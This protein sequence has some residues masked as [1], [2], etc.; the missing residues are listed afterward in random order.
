MHPR[1][2]PRRRRHHQLLRRSHPG[3][4]LAVPRAAPLSPHGAPAVQQQTHPGA[5]R[6]RRCGRFRRRWHPLRPVL[7][8]LHAAPQEGPHRHRGPQGSPPPPRESHGVHLPRRALR[9]QGKVL[10][11]RR[12][13]HGR[14]RPHAGAAHGGGR[15]A[16]VLPHAGVRP[17]LPLPQGGVHPVPALCHAGPHRRREPPA[18]DRGHGRPRG[19][20]RR[21]DGRDGDVPDRREA[22]RGPHERA[23]G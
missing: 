1:P 12:H 22:F 17:H 20:R 16:G 4:H 18:R 14:P 13:R 19:R 21:C 15:P 11:R 5:G 9:R 7:R 3:H 8:L 23:R 6:H 2:V 10:R